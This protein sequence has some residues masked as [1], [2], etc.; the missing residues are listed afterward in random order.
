MAKVIDETR[1]RHVERL[2]GRRA[3]QP[4]NKGAAPC[5]AAQVFPTQQRSME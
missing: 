5:E 4:T 2:P 1:Q 3:R